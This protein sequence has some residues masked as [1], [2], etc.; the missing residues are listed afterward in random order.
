MAYI[1]LIC[2]NLG[3]Q[4]VPERCHMEDDTLGALGLSLHLI[5]TNSSQVRKLRLS[6]GEKTAKVAQLKGPERWG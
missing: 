1:F 2:T 3:Q 4:V 5:L 6:K